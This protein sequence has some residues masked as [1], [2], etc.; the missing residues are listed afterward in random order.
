MKKALGKTSL[1]S[2]NYIKLQD[3]TDV[4]V[5]ITI[6]ERRVKSEVYGAKEVSDPNHY[7][8]KMQG[9]TR[10]AYVPHTVIAVNEAS[11]S[12]SFTIRSKKG[13]ESTYTVRDT[14]VSNLFGSTK[15]IEKDHKAYRDADI[16]KV[17]IKITQA[18]STFA[19]AKKNY[20]ERLK[21][22][23]DVIKKLQKIKPEYCDC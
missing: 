9:K 16:K 13:C 21:K 10:V 22:V 5:G 3:G 12:R 11:N 15:A 7:Y 17:S 14:C 20:S 2:I 8:A 23:N 19:Q 18:H 4:K 1:A 6:Y